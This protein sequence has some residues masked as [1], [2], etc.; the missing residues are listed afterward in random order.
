MKFDFAAVDVECAN[1]DL[2]SICQIGV[3]TVRAGE[4]VDTWSQYIDPEDYFDPMNIRIH[5]ID[6]ITVSGSLTF[7]EVFAELDERLSGVVV[8]HSLFDRGSITRAAEKCGLRFD[9]R[10]WLDSARIARRAWPDQYARR[11]YGLDKVAADLGI[12]FGH[13]GAGEDARAAAEIVLRAC[14]TSGVDID[15][16]LHRLARWT[17]TMPIRRDGDPEGPL[18]GEVLCFTGALSLPRGE[19][20]NMAAA[21]GC[22]VENGVSK[23]TTLL[24]V[25]DQDIRCLAGHDKSANHRK[26]EALIAKGQA[27]RILQE[28]DFRRLMGGP[29]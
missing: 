16:W 4:I 28:S 7:D 3:A 26:A 17:P 13:H 1:A 21:A 19:A 23:R 10:E 20:A 9:A 2:A 8:S 18:F 29:G 27:I 5:G 22:A 25:G 14:A 24:V 15:G 12:A 6:E 11:G